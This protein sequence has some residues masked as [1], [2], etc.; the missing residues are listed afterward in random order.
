MSGPHA[1]VVGAGPAGLA[2]AAMLRAR[3]LEAVVLEKAADVGAT[4][5]RH[6]DRLRL[7]TARGLSG[8]PGL[9]IPRAAGRW[10]ARD[11]VVAYLEAYVQHHR[12]DVRLGTEALAVAREGGA[13]TVRTPG[14]SVRAPAL[15]VATGACRVPRLPAWPGLEA[16]RGEVLHSSQYRSGARFRGR[17]VLVVGAG[18][19][20]AELAV[21][22]VEQGAGRVWLSVRTPPNLVTRSVGGVP[23]QA[24]SI[25]LSPLPLPVA[26]ALAR[27]TARLVVG[28]LSAY[29]LPPARSGV[30]TQMVKDRHIPII[31][32]GLVAL[33]RERRVEV[34]PQ[35]VA[36][37][38]AEVR[39]GEGRSV[40]PDAVVAATGYE[41]GLAPLL[42]H[43]G[44][45]GEDGGPRVHGAE[46]LPMAPGLHFTGFTVP[47]TG[48]LREMGRDARRIAAAIAAAS[49]TTSAPARHDQPLQPAP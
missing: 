15:V 26:D 2:V 3:R 23:A 32:V 47:A 7:H 49:R 43:L 34:V 38:G 16:F 46:T 25:A 30:Y 42:G 37:D 24:I 13:W 48:H 1:V 6:Y 14:G 18:N 39:L 33:L 17:D 9:A 28:D 11:A 35:V 10:P 27:A 40:A 8:L 45:L 41:P 21:D 20:G 22:L 4:W 29:G 44:V 36:F 12:L 31:D 5:R 19:S